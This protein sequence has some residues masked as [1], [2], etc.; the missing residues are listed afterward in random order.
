MPGWDE[1]ENEWRFRIREPGLFSKFRY[2]EIATGVSVI[3]GKLKAGAGWAVQALRFAKGTFDKAAAMKWKTDHPDIGTNEAENWEECSASINLA[4]VKTI[5]K[6]DY[7]LFPEVPIAASGVINGALRRPE[8]LRKAIPFM[9]SLRITLG[10]P[11]KEPSALAAIN[12]VDPNYPV[13]GWTENPHE[14]P[15]LDGRA[16][17]FADLAIMKKDN[18]KIDRTG[19][20]EAMSKREIEEISLGFFCNQKPGNGVIGNDAYIYEETNINPYHLALLLDR[21]AAIPPPIVGI[22]CNSASQIKEIGKMAKE[23]EQGAPPK[24][25]DPAP[26]PALNELKAQVSALAKEKEE[27]AKK[28]KELEEKLKAAE[29]S[30][31][32]GEKA[33]AE[34]ATLRAEERKKKVEAIK[35]AYGE[36]RF[37]KLF[38]EK[39]VE[40]VPGEEL[41][42]HLALAADLA[43]AP[44]EAGSNEKG[45]TF[46][47]L[48]AAPSAG[49]NERRA[50]PHNKGLTVPTIYRPTMARRIIGKGTEFQADKKGPAA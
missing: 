33:R 5:D 35:E 39:V 37:A 28:A 12:L 31:K 17:A 22:G 13:I 30:L 1:T 27:N 44:P 42:R 2:K 46:F 45:K 26:D 50:P 9:G 18:T 34:L 14:G 24:P 6:G 20:I 11:P 4:Q 36:E 23:D 49:K 16:R 10:H 21:P 25:A 19:V 47:A 29:A 38:P 43:Q 8:E 3:Y 48:K 40:T 41:E 15:E 32:D 7:V